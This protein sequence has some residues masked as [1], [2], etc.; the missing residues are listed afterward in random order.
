[1]PRPE[2]IADT[3]ALVRRLRRDPAV[4]P[5]F[6]GKTFAI[7]F[8]TLAELTLGVLKA[9]RPDAAWKQVL[10]L[11][12]GVEMFLVSDST[13][14]IYAGVYRDLEER[15]SMIPI[16]DIWIAALCLEAGL[17]VLARDAHFSRVPNLRVI[18]C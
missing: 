15:G 5:F 13:P 6:A 11:L 3:S 8:V 16:N 2:F 7:T 1:V 14:V 17:P 4:E 12:R 9:D 18:S 10:E